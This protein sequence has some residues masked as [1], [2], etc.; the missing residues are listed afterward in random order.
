MYTINNLAHCV[1]VSSLRNTNDRIDVAFGSLMRPDVAKQSHIHAMRPR[2]D[3]GYVNLCKLHY[4]SKCTNERTKNTPI[5]VENF[6]CVDWFEFPY[7]I[8]P[9]QPKEKHIRNL[10]LCAIFFIHNC[11]CSLNIQ[12]VF[13]CILPFG[14]AWLPDHQTIAPSVWLRELE[15]EN[16]H[17][18]ET[19]SSILLLATDPEKQS[20][21]KNNNN[22]STKIN[23]NKHI[24]SHFT[25]SRNNHM[26][27]SV[28]I[29]VKL[30][31]S[32][33]L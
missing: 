13:N 10:F 24:L 12:I 26:L 9:V 6:N 11:I 7:W 2:F 18:F 32:H 14:M 15:P 1:R 23:K 21:N 19:L 30:I 31:N 8:W 20:N 5:N 3:Q 28:A 16:E 33:L 29:D 4:Y 27:T 22:N 17:I 25:H